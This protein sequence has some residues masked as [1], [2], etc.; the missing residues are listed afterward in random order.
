M[1]VMMMNLIFAA[2]DDPGPAFI[3]NKLNKVWVNLNRAWG[4]Q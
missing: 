2:Y 3:H 1:R 4:L